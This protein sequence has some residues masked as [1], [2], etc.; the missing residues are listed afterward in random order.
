[1]LRSNKRRGGRMTIQRTIYGSCK[2][3]IW[4]HP[5]SMCIICFPEVLDMI[6]DEEE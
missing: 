3:V 6:T 2:H 5:N 4:A 1:M